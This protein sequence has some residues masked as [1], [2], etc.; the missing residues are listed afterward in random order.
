MPSAS[1]LRFPALALVAVLAGCSG[2][3]PEGPLPSDKL[4][5]VRVDLQV[6]LI[7]AAGRM[8]VEPRFELA[9]EMSEGLIGV[10]SEGLWGYAD[11]SG[12]LVIPAIYADAAAFSGGRAAVVV[13]ESLLQAEEDEPVLVFGAGVQS[14]RHGGF[15]DPSGEMVI[16]AHFAGVSSFSEGLAAVRLETLWGYVDESGAWTIDPRFVLA[17]PFSEGLA[18]AAERE[19]E[20]GFIDPTGE[21]AIEPRFAEVY[22]FSEGLAPARADDGTWGFVRADGSWGIEPRFYWANRFADGLAPVKIG[23]KWGYVD[24]SGAVVIEPAFQRAESFSEG[25]AAV[26]DADDKWGYIDTAGEPVGESRW[27]RAEPFG[28]GLASVKLGDEWGWVGLDG[29]VVWEPSS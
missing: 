10:V 15:V 8:V 18:A 11:R 24:A 14:Q 27:D 17:R 1:A 20:V 23:F 2:P 9:G 12:E 3:A 13:D 25:R 5:P 28:G 21:W 29:E 7:D 6:G 26:Q 19:G 22:A 4:F 16:E